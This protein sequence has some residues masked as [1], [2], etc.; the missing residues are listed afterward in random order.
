MV[1]FCAVLLISKRFISCNMS[2]AVIDLNENVLFLSIVD[3]SMFYIFL[4]IAKMADNFVSLHKYFL[5]IL[6]PRFG[7]ISMKNML[8]ISPCKKCLYSKFS[9]P[10][11]PTFAFTL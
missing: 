2:S 1:I 11:S 3:E 7:T 6:V 5:S 8:K 4:S 9:D 10:L